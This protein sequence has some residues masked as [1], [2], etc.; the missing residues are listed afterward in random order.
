MGALRLWAAAAACSSD[1]QEVLGEL[2]ED[3]GYVEESVPFEPEVD[4]GGL[5]A[6]Q[7]TRDHTLVD[8]AGD[9]AVRVTLDEDLGDDPVFEERGFGLLGG[10]ADD[11][12]PGHG[13]SL[14]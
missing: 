3:V 9:A 5:H 2:L 1:G 7:D 4:E 14:P 11:Q 12:V 6:R 13:R 8:V 10:A